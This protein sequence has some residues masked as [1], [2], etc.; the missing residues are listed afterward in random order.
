MADG[1]DEAAHG[2]KGV[3]EV[4]AE[5]VFEECIDGQMGEG[6][7]AAAEADEGFE[8]LNEFAEI[9][10][11][12]HDFPGFGLKPGQGASVGMPL[13]KEILGSVKSLA[14]LMFFNP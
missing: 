8:R 11:H 4:A 7:V 5:D 9:F 3:A 1:F 2:F 12:E 10:R 14:A 6:G 13:E